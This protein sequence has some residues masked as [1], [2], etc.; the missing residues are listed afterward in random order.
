MYTP[1][2]PCAA[3]DSRETV[4]GDSNVPT[5]SFAGRQLGGDATSGPT[6]GTTTDNMTGTIPAAQGGELDCGVPEGVSAVLVNLVAI[7][8]DDIGNFRAYATGGSPTGG[9]LNFNSLSPPLN[10]ANAVL[11]S[12]NGAGDIDLFVNAPFNVGVATT[13]ARGIILGYYS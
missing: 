13:H 5:G 11:G 12:V 4:P 3:F 6:P 2:N 8:A 9:V 1:V 10:N 7:Q